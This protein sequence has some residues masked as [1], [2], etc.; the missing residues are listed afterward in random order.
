[1][2]SYVIETERGAELTAAGI[3]RIR[4]DWR[5]WPLPQ[6]CEIAKYLQEVDNAESARQFVLRPAPQ[7]L[8]V[9]EPEPLLP[10]PS[11]FGTSY[12]ANNYPA[13]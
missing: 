7:V 9:S 10:E 3:Q 12:E 13:N 2:Q 1:M 11:L 5:H 8:A 6:L 4:S